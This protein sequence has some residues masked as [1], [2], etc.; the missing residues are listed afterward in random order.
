MSKAT[1]FRVGTII[2]GSVTALLS[3]F[4]ALLGVAP[5]LVGATKILGLQGSR[6]TLQSHI[7]LERL[8]NTSDPLALQGSLN[9][10]V[11]HVQYLQPASVVG[12]TE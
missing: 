2:I 7:T 11:E 3:I 8:Q 12:K 6:P 5:H 10:D 4:I 9:T 1:E